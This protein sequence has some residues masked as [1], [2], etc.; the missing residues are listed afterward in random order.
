MKDL[1][2]CKQTT[3]FQGKEYSYYSLVWLFKWAICMIM[4]TFLQSINTG[5]ENYIL[6]LASVGNKLYKQSTFGCNTGAHKLS[7]NL[8]VTSYF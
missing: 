7:K 6:L 3:T 1:G 4:L 2:C 5:L 8:I